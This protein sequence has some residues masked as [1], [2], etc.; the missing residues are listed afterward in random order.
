MEVVAMLLSNIYDISSVRLSL[1]KV[2][3]QQDNKQLVKATM[4]RMLEQFD[5]EVPLL[6]PEAILG[7]D[8]HLLEGVHERIKALKQQRQALRKEA[9]QGMNKEEF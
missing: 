6:D 7:E 3:T 8:S 5:H 9:L 1:P 4:G 2:L